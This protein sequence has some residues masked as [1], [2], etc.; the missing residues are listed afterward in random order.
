MK[1]KRFSFGRLFMYLALTVAA[2][3]FIYPFIWMIGASLAPLHQ[4]NDMTLFPKD[5]TLGNFKSLFDKIPIGRSLLNSLFVAVMCTALVMIT[6]S[7]VGYA[8]AKMR[9]RGRQLIFFV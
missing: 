6:G 9:F 5:P 8:L 4:L 3:S 2:L 1:N 7:M